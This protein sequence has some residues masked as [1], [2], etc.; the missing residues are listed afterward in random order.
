MMTALVRHG[1]FQYT[2]E[3]NSSQADLAAKLQ[4]GGRIRFRGSLRDEIPLA[5]WVDGTHPR[6]RQ[7]DAGRDWV[8]RNMLGD[9]SIAKLMYT[10]A[11]KRLGADICHYP[12]QDLPFWPQQKGFPYTQL[13]HDF[14]Q[15][16]LPELETRASMDGLRA[17][18]M[19][20][21]QAGAL[22]V[23][24][25]TCK[26]DAIEFAKVKPERLFV[27]PYG[28]WEVPPISPPEFQE[29]IR[30]RYKLPD[31]FILYPAPTRVHKNHARLIR[32]L[33]SL[34]RGGCRIPLV[35]TG[36]QQPYYDELLRLIRDLGMDAEVLFTDY[37]DMQTLYALYDMATAVVLPTL[38]EGATGLPLLE[39]LSK[40]KPIA[41]ARVCE[42][43]SALGDSGLLF[44]PYSESEIAGAVQRLWESPGLRE[45][46][47]AKARNTN[48]QRSWTNFA[49]VT[50]AAFHHAH[51]HPNDGKN[52]R[53]TILTRKENRSRR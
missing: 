16:H 4:G 50:E 26:A 2:F 1:G 46:L 18:Y 31:Q 43:P 53:P 41:A 40:G 44:D 15:E 20:H 35:T 28:P 23:L 39:A 13:V 14:R 51:D 27:T 30:V 37:I 42:I 45:T 3:I 8:Y 52:W 24:G 34:K 32:A 47:S 7:L 21:R 6:F 9:W 11:A 29:E 48:D 17:E 49:K 10:R 19:G 36:K 25:E 38:F 5:V 12:F 22:C 33:A